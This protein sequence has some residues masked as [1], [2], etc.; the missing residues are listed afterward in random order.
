MD[1]EETIIK[2]QDGKSAE[3]TIDGTKVTDGTNTL[4]LIQKVLW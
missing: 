4:K 1:G 3:Y 2:G